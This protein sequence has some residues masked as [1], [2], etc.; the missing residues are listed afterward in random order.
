MATINHVSLKKDRKIIDQAIAFI[1]SGITL[2]KSYVQT[3]GFDTQ[4]FRITTL[5][6]GITVEESPDQGGDSSIS[7]GYFSPLS[8]TGESFSDISQK[9]K[10]TLDNYF[11]GGNSYF[12]N[13]PSDVNL[14]P[15]EYSY[16]TFRNLYEKKYTKESFTN[17]TFTIEETKN[18]KKYI[19]GTT[20]I[21]Y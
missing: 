12:D 5:P 9:K 3:A 8:N 19:I 11:L 16:E 20:T 18:K 7:V 1:T 17:T 15:S 4:L 13:S 10:D 2:K 21:K 14:K 6:S